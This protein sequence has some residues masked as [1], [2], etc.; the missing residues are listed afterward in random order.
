MPLPFADR[1]RAYVFDAYGTL[2]DVNSAV[3]RHAG[4]IGAAAPAFS[5]L[6]RQKQLEYSWILSLSG[7][8]TDFWTLTQRALDYAFASFPGVDPALRPA[9]LDA[10]RR[11]DAYPEVP[12]LL[13]RLRAKGFDTAILSNGEPAMLADAIASAGIGQHLTHVF[14]VSAV[15]IFKTDPRAYA[16]VLAPLGVKPNQVAFISSNRW[17][18][19]GA[20]CFGFT[21][22]WVNRTGAP[23]EY[24]DLAPVAVLRSLAEL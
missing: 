10:Y 18:V 3:M 6:W 19:A 9:L 12:V 22:I 23:D 4:E 14:S 13:Q 2:F 11:L 24:H 15:G 20:A 1:I 5:A 7:R 8:F 21:P 16:Q 17:D